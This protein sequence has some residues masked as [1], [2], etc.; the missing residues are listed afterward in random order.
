[1][2]LLID[3]QD[4]CVMEHCIDIIAWLE[5]QRSWL[6]SPQFNCGAQFVVSAPNMVRL[7]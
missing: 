2:S 4:V 5:Q 6:S 3:L 7:G 1:M